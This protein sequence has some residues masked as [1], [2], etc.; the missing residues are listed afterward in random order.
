MKLAS[1]DLGSNS[2]L[3]LLCEAD[4]SGISKI[5]SDRVKIVRLGQDLHKTKRIQPEALD[6]AQSCLTEFKKEIDLFR[7]EK[8]LAFATSAARDAENKEDLFKLGKQLNIPIEIISGDKEA[9]ITYQGVFWGNKNLT[10]NA[11]NLLIDIG[12]GSTEIILGQ[13]MK[14]LD[15]MSLNMGAVRMTEKWITSYP[16][17]AAQVEDLR[18]DVVS[19]ISKH[20]NKIKNEQPDL[21]YAVAGTPTTLAAAENKG[22]FQADKIEGFILSQK[23]LEDWENKLKQATLIEIVDQYYIPRERADIILAGVIILNEIL[24]FI[25]KK[26]VQVSTRGVRFGIVADYFVT[27]KNARESL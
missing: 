13:N 17:N 27:N 20:L 23:K 25:N 8:I 18:M 22:Q 26:S 14:L 2:F 11:K 4:G 3:C 12:G 21:V 19:E 15:S 6:R 7:P 5:H 24:K 10:L 1:L 9:Q 16:P